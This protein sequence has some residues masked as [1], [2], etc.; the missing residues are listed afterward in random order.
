MERILQNRIAASIVILVLGLFM[1][2]WPETALKIM[3][4]VIG[5]ILIL[6]GIFMLVNNYKG[7]KKPQIRFSSPVL[8]IV[9]IVAGIAVIV[10]SRFFVSAVFVII[11][12]AMLAG[13]A[14]LF[15]KAYR[16]HDIKGRD[17]FTSL[18]AGGIILILGI[19]M[20]INPVGTASFLIQ[21]AGV[22]FMIAG[23]A[24]LFNRQ[25]I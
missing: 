3:C 6:A 14:A 13:C 10:I 25:A 12:L 18:V 5:V 19:V 15:I 4:N 17:F 1:L 16:L 9:M 21:L 11:G 7:T 8:G 22:A 2:L 20:I 24:M 23:I